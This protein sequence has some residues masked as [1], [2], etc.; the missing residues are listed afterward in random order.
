MGETFRGQN[1]LAGWQ[2]DAHSEE[3]LY[4][5]I[6]LPRNARQKEE[7]SIIRRG[8]ESGL[9]P[10]DFR[11][12]RPTKR[13]P[14]IMT[15]KHKQSRNKICSDFKCNNNEKIKNCV[16]RR[17]IRAL[18]PEEDMLIKEFG[19]SECT[20]Y[21]WNRLLISAVS[22]P[23]VALAM[24]LN[25]TLQGQ[26]TTMQE[27]KKNVESAKLLH[28]NALEKMHKASEKL[29]NERKRISLK[30]L[31]LSEEAKKKF[32][33]VQHDFDKK[34]NISKTTKANVRSA[35]RASIDYR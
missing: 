18:S 28:I 6:P 27:L 34:R 14:A 32:A 3:H 15:T 12:K 25:T 10:S 24:M 19:D 35:T 20:K 23:V 9:L 31:R 33:D 13:S 2:C 16:S 26:Q 4:P 21:H 5:V 11:A 29:D 1:R 7:A 30:N 8:R 17:Q 22:V